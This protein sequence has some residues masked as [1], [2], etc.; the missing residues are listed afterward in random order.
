[1][2]ADGHVVR[3]DL[4]DMSTGGGSW[5]TDP[6]TGALIVQAQASD[7]KTRSTF[8]AADGNPAGDLTVDGQ[9]VYAAVDDGSVPGLMLTYDTSLHGW[10][11]HT[12]AARWSHDAYLTTGALILRGRIYAATSQGVIALDGRTGESLWSGQGKDRFTGAL[13]TDGRHIFTALDV[14]TTPVLVAYDPVS[15]EEAFR[16]QYPEGIGQMGEVDRRLMGYDAATDEYV[17]LG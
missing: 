8:V 17:L 16:A 11:A 10:D 15:G 3:D 5:T 9:L 6:T 1:L 12:G 7:G 4:S 13:F 14:G 2:S